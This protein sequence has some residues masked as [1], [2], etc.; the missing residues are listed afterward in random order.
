MTWLGKILA[1]LVMVLALVWMWFTA[2]VYV[3]RTNWR[4]QAV[5]YKKGFEEARTARESEYRVY[6]SEK[7][8]LARQLKAEQDRAATLAAQ[9]NKAEADNLANIAKLAVLTK[10]FTDL[11][12]KA[13]VLQAN[14]DTALAR[15]DK[16]QTRNTELEDERVALIRSKETADRERE[17]AE[18]EARQAQAEKALADRRIEELTDQ[19]ADAR[20]GRP[21][22]PLRN[23]DRVPAPVP[24]GTRGTVLAYENGLIAISLGI[25]SGVVVGSQLDVYRESNGGRYL[26]TVVIDRAYAKQAVGTFRPADPRRPVGQLR[27]EERPKPD[28]IVGKV[29]SISA[30]R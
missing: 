26:G 3:A 2:S 1:V 27:P 21:G 14:L 16:L 9:V 23:L 17:A 19:V 13:T 5:G 6:L 29:G 25:D 20:D 28:D 24:E 7:D 4:D 10:G 11:N 18:R 15:A 12:E 8:A 22:G 30:G